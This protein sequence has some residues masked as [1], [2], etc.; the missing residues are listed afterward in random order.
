MSLNDADINTIAGIILRDYSH[1]FPTTYPDIPLNLA[2]LRD[3]LAKAGFSVEK[4]E[5]PDL[6]QRVE[7]VFATLVPLNWNNYGTIALL[8]N[9]L[10]PDE[11]LLTISES[12]VSELTRNLPNFTDVNQPD[13]DAID[14]IIYTWISLTDEE[15]EERDSHAWS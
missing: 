13:E 8:L 2:M 15:P 5:I 10:F 1:L 9:Q 4:P 7:L 6:M 14:S 11:D 12:R 3:A